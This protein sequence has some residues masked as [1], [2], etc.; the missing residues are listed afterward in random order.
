MSSYYEKK[1]ISICKYMNSIF[2]TFIIELSLYWKNNLDNS[3]IMSQMNYYILF[4]KTNLFF[5]KLTFTWEI[6]L[7]ESIYFF[8]ST[9]LFLCWLLI[10]V[11]TTDAD[12]FCK[13]GL[14][15][16]TSWIA[17]IDGNLESIIQSLKC[18]MTICFSSFVQ[19]TRL[20]RPYG[21]A[22]KTILYSRKLMHITALLFFNTHNSICGMN[23]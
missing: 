23:V 15:A 20:V 9:P 2:H 11:F 12:L 8:F 10:H 3:L 22:T 4:P 14:L 16:I 7:E 18:S 1:N 19:R 5:L 6:K 21:G 17:L 13:Q